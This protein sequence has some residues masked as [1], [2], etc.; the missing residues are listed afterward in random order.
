M[1]RLLVVLAFAALA[2]LTAGRPFSVVVYNVENLFDADGVSAYDD[3]R[4]PH[5]MPAHL[6]TKLANIA[7][8]LSK[9]NDGDGPDIILFNE[10]EA[11]QT[12]SRTS[13]S[14]EG[15]DAIARWLAVHADRRY[16]EL[17]A[18]DPLPSG[19]ADAPSHWWLLKALHDEGIRGHA[20]VSGDDGSGT[21][22][23][24]CATFTRFPVKAAK[25]HPLQN[26]R[27]IV[28]AQLDVGGHTLFVFNNH[29]KSGASDRATEVD[30]RANARTL[31]ARLDAILK[32]DPNAD[33]LIGGDL[34]SHYN[35]NKRYRDLRETGINDILRSQGNELAVRGKDRDLYNLWFELPSHQR[36]SDA[37]RGEWGTLMHLIVSRGLY[38][39]RGVQY[40]DNSF[41]VLKL[42]GVNAD[43]RGLPVRW[44]R[45][46]R[47]AGAGFSDH[48]PLIARFN[49]A[50]QGRAD[51]W[52]ALK[53]PTA[54][55]DVPGVA[56]RVDLA[57]VELFK[58]A[59][60]IAELPADADLR[61]G[62]FNGRIFFIE[63][64]GYTNE[65]GHVK[66]RVLGQ[67][68][69]VYS[70]KKDVRDVLRAQARS[71]PTIRF[72]GELG[73]YRGQWQFVVHDKE[74]LP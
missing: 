59:T 52:L 1:L 46:T 15:G 12:P 20:V 5:Y 61:D 66:V 29:W 48:F 34:N 36:A 4:P 14:V 62:S 33:I 65:R 43:S 73:T 9:V 54:E 60:K 19:L 27:P 10:L 44:N 42:T 45:F 28:E 30:R 57:P 31:R 11:D 55:D 3:Y 56:L 47:P 32:Q 25:L 72:Y 64:R 58:T 23:I 26:A 70:H 41:A 67:E 69:D 39:Q 74:W 51:R 63:T 35:Q 40:E 38:D 7:G 49:I 6:A 13:D 17:L 8:V 22:A 24:Q 71:R 21:R 18:V 68:Y 53:S 16:D 50:K 37:Y 2:P